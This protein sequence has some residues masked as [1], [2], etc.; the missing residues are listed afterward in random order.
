MDKKDYTRFTLSSERQIEAKEK[1]L[2]LYKSTPIPDGDILGNF[3]L[4]TRSVILAKLLYLNELYQQVLSVPGIV[5]EFGVWWGSNLA[6]F[7]SFRSVYE[8]YNFTRKVVGFDTFGGYASFSPE[9]GDSPYVAEWSKAGNGYLVTE[10]YDDYLREVLDAH[11]Q[12]NVV[13][14][15]R[16]Y[17][18]VKGNVVQTIGR[19]LDKNPETVI[20]LAYFDLALYEPTKKCLEAIRP[21]LVRGSVLAMDELN[22][23]NF[24]GETIALREVLGLD[25]YRIAKSRFLHDRSYIII[26]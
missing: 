2:Q 6:L 18:I 19:Y 5:V 10:R 26:D 17:D 3:G 23:H 4:Y 11:E 24:P 8:P 9:D 13:S 15:I 14:H 25:R 12:D 22:S 1:L 7:N 16:K 20:A 21:H